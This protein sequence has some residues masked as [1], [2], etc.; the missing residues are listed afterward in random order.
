MARGTWMAQWLSICLQLRSWSQGPGIKPHVGPPAQWGACFSHS[1]CL[2][3]PICAGKINTY[4]YVRN[5]LLYS[6]S[7]LHDKVPQIEQLKTIHE[8]VANMW[9]GCVPTWKPERGKI[10]C[11]AFGLL[12]GLTSLASHWLFQPP[13]D[14]KGCQRSPAP[15]PS[16]EAI[17]NMA[18]CLCKDGGSEFLASEETKSPLKGL[19][20]KPSSPRIISLPIN[21]KSMDFEP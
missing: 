3:V 6:F 14:P 21:S 10:H 1:L 5:L 9:P 4:T 2:P 18:V 20:S 19:L 13:S 17:D 8:P 12:D 11:W 16:P 7:R 15:G